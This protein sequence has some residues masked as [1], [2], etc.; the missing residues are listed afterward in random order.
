[1]KRTRT[2]IKEI[3][4]L[5]KLLNGMGFDYRIPFPKDRPLVILRYEEYEPQCQPCILRFRTLREAREHLEQVF[6]DAV[7]AEEGERYRRPRAWAKEYLAGELGSGWKISVVDDERISGDH[8][9]GA[10]I[11][12]RATNKKLNRTLE[13]CY[14]PVYHVVVLHFVQY[15]KDNEVERFQFMEITDQA[16]DWV[17]ADLNLKGE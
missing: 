12:A 2:S 5:I 7:A 3:K 4:Q 13:V 14:D 8:Y 6:R 17:L 11:L 9:D 10:E 15:G 16:P 1:M